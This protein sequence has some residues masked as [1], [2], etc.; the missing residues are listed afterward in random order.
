[1]EVDLVARVV[2]GDE[3]VGGVAAA[4]VEVGAGDFEG[5]IL[6]SRM[7]RFFIREE[8]GRWTLRTFR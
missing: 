2:A 5:S 1:V 3:V 8:M 6:R 4:V 7:E